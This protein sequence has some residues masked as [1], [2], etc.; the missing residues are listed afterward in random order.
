[1]TDPDPRALRRGAARTASLIA[2]PFALAI[3]AFSLWRFGAFGGAEPRPSSLAR[4][5]RRP[6]PSRWPPRRCRTTPPRSAG[7]LIAHL[8]DAVHDANRR[9]VTAGAEQNAAYGDPALTLPAARRR[10][11]SPRPTTCFRWRACASWPCP[12]RPARSGPRWTA[13]AGRGHGP[14]RS[15]RFRAAVM[16]LPP[17]SR[18]ATPELDQTLRLRL[19][20]PPSARRTARPSPPATMIAASVASSHA[21][22]SSPRPKQRSC[23]AM[24]PRGR[25]P[26]PK[27]ARSRRLCHDTPD[28]L[29]QTS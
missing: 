6:A 26:H 8:P 10:R 4:P 23:R 20:R 3:G 2:I 29:A 25:D 27:R 22:R 5:P 21:P 15:G 24:E 11:R 13:S 18:P 1:M 12:R 14:R 16:P 17:R 28:W 7:P 9:P 19:T